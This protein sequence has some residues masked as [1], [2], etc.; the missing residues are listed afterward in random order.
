MFTTD[1]EYRKI[2]MR[3]RENP[4]EF[5]LAFAKV[6]AKVMNLDPFD[7]QK[8]GKTNLAGGVAAR[9]PFFFS[10]GGAAAA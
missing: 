4:E 3:L 7:L 5:R 10:T 1:P 2:A 9:R 8:S 6:W